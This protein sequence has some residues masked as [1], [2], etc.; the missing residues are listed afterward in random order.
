L[1]TRLRLRTKVNKVIAVGITTAHNLELGVIQEGEEFLEIPSPPFRRKKVVH[2]PEPAPE[3]NPPAI[4][5][6]AWGEPV[7]E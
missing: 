4:G 2:P 1:A 6:D 3:G 5:I 7:Y